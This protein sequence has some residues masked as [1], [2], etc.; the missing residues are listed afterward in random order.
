LA[1]D[2]GQIGANRRLWDQRVS[3]HQR[4]AYYDVDGFRAGRS[5]LRP[6]EL[7]ELGDVAGRSLL[8]LQCHFG[9]DTLSLARLGAGVTGVD[10]SEPAIAAARSL[11]AE[12]GLQARFLCS[13]VYELTRVLHEQFDVV[14]TSYGVLCWLPD[15]PEWA[16]VVARFL[17]PGGTFVIVDGH[18]MAACFEEVDGRMDVAHPLFQREPFEVVSTGTYADAGAVLPAVR[19]Y[20]WSWTVAGMVS[21]LI[22]AGLRVERLRELPVDCWQ[23]FPSMTL[24]ERGWWRLPGDPLPLLVACRAVKPL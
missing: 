21:A 2:R 23:R 20:Q 6:I 10:F 13:D 7:E 9:L 12:L 24:D 15:I 18:P 19:N 3:V 17:R 4:S 14:F 5:T 11:S 22:D 8:H 1:R 16:R